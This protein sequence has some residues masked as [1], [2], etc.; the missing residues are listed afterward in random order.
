MPVKSIGTIASETYH[1]LV[2]LF[3]RQGEINA[4][5]LARLDDLEKRI[6]KVDSDL[7]SEAATLRDALKEVSQG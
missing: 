2:E 4:N 5:V 7:Y 3:R 6:G 1:L